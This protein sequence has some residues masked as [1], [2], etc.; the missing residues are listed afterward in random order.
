MKISKIILVGVLILATL[1]C[2]LFSYKGE[3]SI[4]ENEVFS[5]TIPAGWGMGLYGGEYYDLG[6]EKIVEVYDPPILP[7]A[8]FT[9]AT[10]PLDGGTDLETR[11]TQTYEEFEIW[12]ASNMQAFKH[13]TLSGL[14]IFY[15]HPNGEWFYMFHDI[16]LEKDGLIYVLSF[17]TPRDQFENYTDIFEQILDGFR[18]K[19]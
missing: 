4:Y 2:V 18:F 8:F 3:E 14:E 6:V 11:F 13:D 12:N 10:S 7:T 16:W 15:D 5:F 1:S 19:E 17:S 9:V